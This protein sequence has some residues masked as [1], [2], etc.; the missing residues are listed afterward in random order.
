MKTPSFARLAVTL[1]VTAMI[2]FAADVSGNYKT[3]FTAP[4]G[5]TR[6]GT[7][8]LKAEGE[9]LSGSVSGRQGE[10]PITEG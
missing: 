7:M 9:K 2:S 6:E 4:D 8:T 3:S 1:F 10:T 5:Q